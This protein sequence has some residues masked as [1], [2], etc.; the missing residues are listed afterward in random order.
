MRTHYISKTHNTHGNK[1]TGIYGKQKEILPQ[2]KNIVCNISIP[3]EI[4]CS[5][6]A[7]YPNLPMRVAIRQY[8][9]EHVTPKKMMEL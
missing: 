7:M 9:Q 5:I 4:A 8:L 6:Q 1:H 3:N 2:P